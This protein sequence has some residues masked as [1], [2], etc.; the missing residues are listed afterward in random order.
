[1]SERSQTPFE[2]LPPHVRLDPE[3]QSW[4]LG[5]LETRVAALEHP[6]TPARHEKMSWL[7][8]ASYALPAIAALLG[9]ISPEQALKLIMGALGH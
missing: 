9:I 7:K 6:E 5:Q 8:T 1:M 4:R 2:A 3:F